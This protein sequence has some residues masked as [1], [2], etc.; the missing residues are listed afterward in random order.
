MSQGELKRRQGEMKMSGRELK[1]RH[2]EMKMQL[3]DFF[4]TQNGHI[5]GAT[6]GHG[7][8]DVK[9]ATFLVVFV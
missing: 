3:G 2:R 5:S 1:R 6:Y 7:S 9:I 4:Y 8:K